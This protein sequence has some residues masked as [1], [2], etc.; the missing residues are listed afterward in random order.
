MRDF[1]KILFYF[2]ATA[3][4]ASLIAPPLYWLGTSWLHTLPGLGML[5]ETPFT[6]YFSRA[7][8]VAAVLLLFPLVWW[9]KV[10]RLSE[11]GLAKNPRRWEHF[12]W[13][14]FLP[15]IMLWAYGF[16]LLQTPIYSMKDPLPWARLTNVLPTAFAVSTIEELFFRGALLGLVLRTANKGVA[17][18]LV[19]A[20]FSILHFLKPP[21]SAW[22]AGE[23]TWAS[24]FL[25]IPQAFH[26]FG[27]PLLVLGGFAV[28]FLLSIILCDVTLR[29]RSLWLALGLHAGL[30]VAARSFSILAQRHDTWLPWIGPELR[31]GVFSLILLGLMWLVLWLFVLRKKRVI[32]EDEKAV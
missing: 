10:R 17:V 8:L 7:F 2:I 13:G 26:Q 23:V 1:V 32:A 27:E 5:E 28:L 14:F 4:L 9:L 29:T 11:L 22:E 15:I 21:D 31:V 30:I 16:I 3:L 19:S 24:G 25:L 12:A 18:V 6:R 20:L